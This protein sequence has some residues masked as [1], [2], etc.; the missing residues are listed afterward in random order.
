MSSPSQP[1]PDVL[2]YGRQQ[3]DERD[4]AA[5]VEV[6]RS[7]LLTQGPAVPA[8]EQALGELTGAPHAVAV[9]NG[10]AALHLA[11]AALGVGPGSVVLTSAN[12]FLSTATAA[13]MC[14]GTAEFLD[15]DPA[16]LNLDLAALQRRL[17]TGAIPDVV[18]AVHF[19]GLPCD[20]QRLVD[21]KRAYGFRLVED[22]AHALGARYRI[23]G[24]WYGI[25]AHPEVDAAT[26]SFHPVKH[27]TTGEGGAVLTSDPEVDARLRRLRCHGLDRS[28]DVHA[29]DQPGEP[30][31]W[32]TP[33]VELGF[34]YRLSDL[35]AA[36]G[37]S[38]LH[39]LTAF[40]DERRKVAA[41]YGEQLRG[42]ELPHAGTPDLEHAWHLFV[43]RP[44]AGERDALMRDLR[45]QGIVTQLHYYPVPLQPWFRGR[46]DPA[47][48][49]HAI[50]YAR[51]ALSIPLHA[52]LDAADQERV[53]EALHAWRGAGARS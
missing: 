10:T 16:T 22:A 42:F 40:L 51:T 5:V 44:D 46:H 4:I 14:G 2:G 33:M 25:G 9:N 17:E 8:F 12:T 26:L 13:H 48:Y 20:M 32:F 21:L 29:F 7:D 31:P 15:I 19:A 27:I 39:K 1:G 38:Q 35:H 11:Y 30:Q 6:L 50:E 41:R 3:I 36:L 49:P 52:A 45:A 18:C 23:D 47:N 53:V 24:A 28:A 37:R 43:V 34:N